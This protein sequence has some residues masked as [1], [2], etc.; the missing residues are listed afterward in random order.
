M[1]LN[2]PLFLLLLGLLG[3]QAATTAMDLRTAAAMGE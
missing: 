2:T 1:T 3:A